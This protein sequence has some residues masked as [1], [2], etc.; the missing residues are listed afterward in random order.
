MSKCQHT[1]L[2]P[3]SCNKMGQTLDGWAWKE[4][5]FFELSQNWLV[6]V[7]Q[8]ANLQ[9][10]F[11]DL[12]SYYTFV[13]YLYTR[14]RE[15]WA[16]RDRTQKETFLQSSLHWTANLKRQSLLQDNVGLLNL[17]ACVDSVVAKPE[18]MLD[19][20]GTFDLIQAISKPGLACSCLGG[21]ID[22]SKFVT[23]FDL[24]R[25]AIRVSVWLPGDLCIAH[26]ILGH[27]LVFFK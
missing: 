19:K 18:N 4:S 23:I 15:K 16:F 9:G 22:H 6:S 7:D 21:I 1:K 11:R 12:K 5:S 25:E 8:S 2:T 27:L 10:W 20:A 3:I 17:A 14:H 13:L 26:V 24:H